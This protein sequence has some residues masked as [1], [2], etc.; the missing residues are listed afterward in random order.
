MSGNTEVIVIGG[1]YAGVMAA[2][3]LTKEPR[4]RQLVAR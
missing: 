4:R 1:G 3:R 2:D